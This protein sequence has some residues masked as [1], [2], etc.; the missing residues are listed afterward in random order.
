VCRD[1]QTVTTGALDLKDVSSTIGVWVRVRDSPFLRNSGLIAELWSGGKGSG[2]DSEGSMRCYLY[3][4]FQ[5]NLGGVMAV[6]SA[7][8]F[9]SADIDVWVH[10]A[11]TTDADSRQMGLWRG[12]EKL[13]LKGDGKI[14]GESKRS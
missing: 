8:A 4:T 1:R 5:C 14:D 6:T 9:S 10:L 2:D 12:G 3:D 13:E 7:A 11:V